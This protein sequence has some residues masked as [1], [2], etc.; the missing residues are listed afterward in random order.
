MLELANSAISS[1]QLVEQINLFRKEELRS[2]LVHSDLLKVIRDEFEEEI[3]EGEI[4]L[5]EY[6]DKKGELRPMFNLTT[7]QAKQVLVRESKMVRK[8]VI[9]YIEK[10]EDML[11]PKEL[12]RKELA[13][14]VVKAEEEKEQLLLQVDN[15]STAL[16]TLVEWVSIL[17]VA[18]KNKISEK[19]FDW[20]LL[21]A[22]SNQMGFT[23]KK[24]ESPRYG[25]QNLYHVAVFKA[26]YP[27]YNY[28][29]IDKMKY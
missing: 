5:V 21:K 4:S 20:H 2:D 12:T 6:K 26:C 14:M 15:L 1:L 24:A 3:N 25:Y 7:S 29:F 27:E 19:N 23:I 11:K 18:N 16:D 28:S 9:A 17:K 8:A 13:L 10:L 22:K